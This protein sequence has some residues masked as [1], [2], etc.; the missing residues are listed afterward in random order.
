MPNWLKRLPARKRDEPTLAAEGIA[1]E[2]VG[3]IDAE[4][5]LRRSRQAHAQTDADVAFYVQK[6]C[7]AAARGVAGV[8]EN[9]DAWRCQLQDFAAE[10]EA[11]F[12]VEDEGAAA[13]KRVRAIAAEAGQAVGEELLLGIHEPAAAHGQAVE[14]GRG[15]R[16]ST[17]AP[18]VEDG[19]AGDRVARSAIEARRKSNGRHEETVAEPFAV[20]GRDAEVRGGPVGAERLRRYRA[21]DRVLPAEVEVLV[22]N[23]L[24]DEVEFDEIVGGAVVPHE[25]VAKLAILGEQRCHAMVHRRK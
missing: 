18:D 13:G 10:V 21:L 14:E 11:L 17:A 25:Q 19:R 2:G 5:V 20:A 24:V 12:D 3:E 8:G 1:I 7:E 9:D 22:T 4:Q 16:V 6:I 15:I 23:V